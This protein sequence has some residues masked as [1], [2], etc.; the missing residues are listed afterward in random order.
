MAEQYGY[1]GKILKVDL[2]SGELVY[3]RTMEYTERFLGGRGIAAKIYWDEQSP[4][5]G[6]MDPE[7]RLM[8][9]TGPLAG[10]PGLSGSRWTVCGKSPVTDPETFCTCNLGGSWGAHLKLAGY[11][12][13]V[14]HG[15]ADKPVYL[16]VQDNTVELRDA[17]TLWGQRTFYVRDRLKEELGSSVRVVACGPAGENRVLFASL[18]AD[19]DAS[20]SGGFGAVMGS[21]NLKAIA[22]RGNMKPTAANPEDLRELADVIRKYISGSPL[23]LTMILRGLTPGPNMKKQVCYGCSGIGCW[24][25]TYEASD[26]TKGKYMCGSSMFYQGLAYQYYGGPNEVPF[27]ATKLCDDYGMDAFGIASAITWLRRCRKTGILT[28]EGIG[29]P[30]S[31]KGSLEFIQSFVRKIALRE[32]FG[33]ILA[34]GTARA[35][36]IVGGESKELLKGMITEYMIKAEE[37]PGGDPRLFS[38]IALFHAMEPR[39]ARYQYAET[40]RPL[41][42][43]L[44]WVNNEEGAYVTSD[45]WRAVARKYLGGETAADFSTYDGKALAVKMVQ[46]RE[47]AIASLILCT[48]VWPIMT[49]K[50]SADH[51]GDPTLESRLLS[52]VTSREMDESGLRRIGEVI[53]NLERAIRVREGHRGR[54]SDIL[55]E[56]YFTV[57]LAT[58]VQDPECLVPGK[59]GEIISRKGEVVDRSDFERLKDEFYRLRGWDTDTGLQTRGILKALGLNEVADDLERR[60]LLVAL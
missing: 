31:E 46:D 37:P 44:A 48:Y 4:K 10:F 18:L 34:Q 9:M 50:N 56:P 36:D 29:I 58:N 32:G 41:S 19:E 13:I 25:E 35:A 45:V 2:S 11:D 3:L 49:V 57:P 51:V 22:V 47:S 15:R 54:E 43:W 55:P 60:K 40:I 20:G 5:T 8:F 27:L 21:K 38:P 52:A 17:S 23:P 30:I 33:D 28:E 6:A 53:F 16:F 12:G 1:A 14:I 42:S 7:S 59:D 24:R 26:G 39:V